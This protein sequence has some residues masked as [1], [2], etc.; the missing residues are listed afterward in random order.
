MVKFNKKYLE[1]LKDKNILNLGIQVW[2]NLTKLEFDQLKNILDVKKIDY[3]FY[4]DEQD[5]YILTLNYYDYD[6]Y[7]NIFKNYNFIFDY[8]L[9]EDYISDL[10]NQC[11][12]Y[13][14]YLLFSRNYGWDARIAYKIASNDIDLFY[15][16]YDTNLYYENST[17]NGKIIKMVETSHDAP[18]G[19]T[20]YYIGLTNQ[21]YEKIEQNGNIDYILKKYKHQLERM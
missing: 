4:D 12:T 9:Q 3:Y 21:E 2:C 16:D 14:N 11:F 13:D 8:D 5:N 10:I 6:E 18:M 17:K 1:N 20:F 19:S 7:Y 15:R